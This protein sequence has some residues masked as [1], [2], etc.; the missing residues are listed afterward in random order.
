LTPENRARVIRG[1]VRSVE[2]NEKENRIA[3]TFAPLDDTRRALLIE[4]P[5][6]L[7]RVVEG[8]LHRER[9]R[10]VSFTQKAPPAPTAPVRR[11]AK[12]ARMLALAHHVDRSIVN[13]THEDLADVARKLTL[14]RAR[15]SQVVTLLSL[16]PD[17]QAEVL[18]LESIDGMEPIHERTLRPIAH[19]LPWDKQ[20]AA[21]RRLIDA[22]KADRAPLAL[23]RPPGKKARPSVA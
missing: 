16:A 12:V 4:S 9:S 14:T 7:V 13:G 22:R 3:I 15:I 8:E 23:V 18:A 20:R 19:V 2:A 1:M 10:S 11:P 21:W 6:S 5:D 17:I